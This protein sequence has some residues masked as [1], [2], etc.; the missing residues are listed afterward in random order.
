MDYDDAFSIEPGGG[1]DSNQPLIRAAAPVR[2]IPSDPLRDHPEEG[3][4]LCLSGGG[5]RAMLF[6]A[7][8]LW[9]LNDAG[10]L[11]QLKR[12][13]SVSGGS[14]TAA[15]LAVE[16]RNLGFDERGVARH[17]RQHL[18]APIHALAGRT[19]D[20]AATLFG[21]VGPGTSADYLTAAYR[22]HLFGVRTLRVL[23][24]DQ[25]GPRF[26]INA[27]NLQSGVL[28]RFS[29]PYM[30]DY[31]V[32]RVDNPDVPV[33]VAVAASSAFP[34]F[35]SP[36]ALD[37]RGA[38]VLPDPPS[39]A[40][41]LSSAPY[42]TRPLL[43]DG[44]VYDNLGL[45]TAW[46]RYRTVL[47]SDAGA[48]MQPREQ[49]WRDWINQF[50]RV[51][52]IEDSQVRALRK[53]Q[54]FAAYRLPPGTEGQRYGAYWSMREDLDSYKVPGTE[55]WARRQALDLAALPTRLT[56]LGK[57]TREQLINWGFAV[58]DVALRRAVLDG[59]LPLA[60]QLEPPVALPYPQVDC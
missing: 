24:D 29:R 18:V 38:T 60:Q 26:V 37:L 59:H 8:V 16:W 46:K 51:R 57:S 40:S 58:C 12:V 11:A 4:A 56:R 2:S 48:L 43:T 41:P 15:K 23:P 27:T 9:R 54:I 17:F 49:L 25:H 21:I 33:A 1:E 44:G 28:W 36:L 19:I 53:R 31:R 50:L 55:G 20:I 52:D 5:Y 47:V 45:E 13:S 34:P 10:L 30:A 6:H 14:I 32:G 7:G 39:A 35:L 3:I 22:R 42:T